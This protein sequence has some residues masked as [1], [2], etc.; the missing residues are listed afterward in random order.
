METPAIGSGRAPRFL[1]WWGRLPGDLRL[2]ILVLAAVLLG[3]AGNVLGD[4]LWM[5][6]PF[7]AWPRFWVHLR[8]GLLQNGLGI[9]AARAVWR[10]PPT[11][12]RDCVRLI[13]AYMAGAMIGTLIQMDLDS[14]SPGSELPPLPRLYEV[15]QEFVSQLITS[16]LV[17]GALCWWRRNKLAQQDLHRSRIGLQA[18]K[19]GRAE[20][21][22]LRLRAQIEPHFLFNTMATIVELY[23]TDAREGNR[24]LAR[25]IDYLTAARGYMRQNEATLTQELGLAE[26]YLAIQQV[27]MGPRLRYAID[28]PQPLRDNRI[29]PAALLTLIENAIKHGLG[30]QP[31]GGAVHIDARAEQGWLVLSVVD[32]G[33]GFRATRG[34]GLGLANLRA[35]L[36]GLYGEGAGLRLMSGE[37]GGVVA[38][39]RLPL[40]PP[41]VA[42]R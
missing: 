27:R 3:A 38:A 25:L 33:A 39:L 28:V 29:P 42:A 34:R 1:Q 35:R 41:S 22:L 7:D 6:P 30:P 18:M 16:S 12:L 10:G 5:P 36:L 11:G 32:D 2:A 40:G 37:T 17:V 9:V 24:T 13:A 19:V 21:E 26:G 23:R 8:G 15:G 14:G 4:F 20:A 31:A